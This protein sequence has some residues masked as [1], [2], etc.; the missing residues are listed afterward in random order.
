MK[1][2]FYKHQL[3]ASEIN[4]F[5]S[6]IKSEILTTGNEV[7][8]FEDEFSRFLG[9]NHCIAV[10]SCTAGLQLCLEAYEFKPNSEVITTPLTYIATALS[11]LQAK[12]KPVFCDVDPETGN[13]DITKIENYITPKT[14]AIMP[15]HLYGQMVDMVTLTKI[16]KEN[17]LVCIEDAAHCVEGKKENYGPG[18]LSEAACFSFYAT[19]NITCGEGGCITTNS[20]EL[21]NKLRML[22][23]H[24]VSK[25]AFDRH[26]DGYSHW[27]L[28]TLGWKYNLDNL[29]ASILRPQLPLIKEKLQSRENAAIYYEELLK[30]INEVNL[31]VNEKN[32]VHARHL[33][34]IR[35]PCN[36]RDNLIK[37]LQKFNIGIVVNYRSLNKYNLL[38]NESL[39]DEKSFINASKIGDEVLSL[40][41]YPQISKEEIEFVVSKI[42]NYFKIN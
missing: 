6:A 8:Q 17:N 20:T 36:H 9:T 39:Y 38:L 13:I 12:L 31:F 42:S 15:V 41:M 22:R 3:G 26:K 19:K 21:A 40:P 35:V 28:K 30:E 37:Y 32:I 25:I 5:S 27:E 1:V 4:A 18:S 29:H 24:G 14:V 10:Q 2:P 11:I 33:F 23:S 34:P 7:F 16:A